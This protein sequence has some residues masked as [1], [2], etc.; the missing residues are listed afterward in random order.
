MSRTTKHP[1][2]FPAWRRD[3]LTKRQVAEENRK[4]RE[5]HGADDVTLEDLNATVSQIKRAGDRLRAA[6]DKWNNRKNVDG[7]DGQVFP[8]TKEEK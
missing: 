8:F 3:R 7:V 1:N 5:R 6:R 4:R 2:Q